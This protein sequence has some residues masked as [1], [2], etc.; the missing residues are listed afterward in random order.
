ML[1]VAGRRR[2]QGQWYEMLQKVW[3][4][5]RDQRM[6]VSSTKKLLVTLRPGGLWRVT[7]QAV[8]WWVKESYSEEAESVMNFIHVSAWSLLSPSFSWI[9]LASGVLL[10]ALWPLWLVIRVHKTSLY[11]KEVFTVCLVRF[12]PGYRICVSC[13]LRGC[14]YLGLVAWSAVPLSQ[15]L[16]K[17]PFFLN[18]RLCSLAGCLKL[19]A[20]VTEH[21]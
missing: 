12:C 11:R 2:F 19:P 1:A 10:L 15:G 7:K 21:K 16:R 4:E 18:C 5:V 3:I 17:K 14:R 13:F 9:E 6:F 20:L 8:C